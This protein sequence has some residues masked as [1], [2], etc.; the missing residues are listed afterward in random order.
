VSGSTSTSHTW[1][2][3]GK[4]GDR[5]TS[6]PEIGGEQAAQFPPA[7]RDRVAA[8]RARNQDADVAIGARDAES[9]LG[10]FDIGDAGLEQ[11]A[12]DAAALSMMS[13]SPGR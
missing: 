6:G 8:A 4:P 1:G 12:G 3:K 5:Q 7:G 11:M 9:S 10:E 13:S 2:A